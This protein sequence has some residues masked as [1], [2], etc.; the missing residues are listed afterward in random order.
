MRISTLI[1]SL[2]FAVSMFAQQTDDM[3]VPVA[4]APRVIVPAAA[5]AAGAN[6]TF[7]RSDLNLI[8]LRNVPQFVQAFWLPQ[9]A[10]GSATPIKTFEVPPLTG[11]GSEDF[12]GSLLGTSGLGAIEFVGVNGNGTFDPGALL[13]VTQRVW[14]PRPDGAP[15]TMSQTFPAIPA[16]STTAITHR[17]VLGM[18]RSEQ[19]RLNVGVT[20]PS[21]AAQTFHFLIH[22]VGADRTE[23][24]QFDLNLPPRSMH[25][26]LVGGTFAGTAQVLVEDVGGGAGDW[27]T[28]ASSVDNQSGDAWSQMGVPVS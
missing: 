8:N 24:I 26:V 10:T 28:W 12:V 15:G 11:I 2:L 9:M 7:F 25:Q 14:T 5:S 3:F 22:I 18:R 1:A 19:Y 6:G 4:A 20:N 16:G 17:S 27:H 13:H 21:N 23:T